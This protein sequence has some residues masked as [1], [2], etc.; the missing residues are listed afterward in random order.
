MLWSTSPV[1]EEKEL[2]RPVPVTLISLFCSAADTDDV[3]AV[4]DG[5]DATI[6][7]SAANVDERNSLVGFDGEEK[8]RRAIA[9]V[10]DERVKKDGFLM[11]PRCGCWCC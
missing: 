5:I 4:T 2:Y 6:T 10:G 1:D 8:F 9:A 11:P 3:A 7:A